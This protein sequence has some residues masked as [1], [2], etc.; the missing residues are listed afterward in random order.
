MLVAA[1]LWAIVTVQVYVVF[2]E[3]QFCFV[4]FWKTEF[5]ILMKNLLI[6]VGKLA[7]SIDKNL[8]L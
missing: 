2:L 7:V 4:L 8:K 3:L 1:H 5:K 6:D